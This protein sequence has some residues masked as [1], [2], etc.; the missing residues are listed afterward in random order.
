MPRSFPA[1]FAGHCADCGKAF[2]AG[3][4]IEF[5]D[6]D[7]RVVTECCGELSAP[8]RGDGTTPLVV[9]PRGR[10]VADRCPNCFLIPSSNGACGCD[11]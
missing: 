10:T 5:N 7:Q 11:T 2:D 8:E 6:E 9:M 4:H 1:A 3:D